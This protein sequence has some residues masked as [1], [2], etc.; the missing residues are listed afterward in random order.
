MPITQE[1]PNKPL[2]S[3]IIP[4]YNQASF[5]N[6]TF[7]SISDQTYIHWEAIIIDDGSTDNTGAIAIDWCNKDGRFKYFYKAN[8]GLSDARN[9]GISKALGQYIQFLDSDDLISPNKLLLQVASLEKNCADVSICTSEFF[10]DDNYHNR[11]INNYQ[12][13]QFPIQNASG[14]DLLPLFL[15][16]NRFPVSSPLLRRQTIFEAGHFDT[17]LKSLEDWDYWF[18][19]L[20]LDKKF[21]LDFTDEPLT[22]IRI[23]NNSMSTNRTT[24]TVS[25][26][27]VYKKLLGENHPLLTEQRK[28]IQF[29]IHDNIKQYLFDIE[30]T[31]DYNVLFNR[32]ESAISL[33]L[34]YKLYKYIF[35]LQ[36]VSPRK[37]L[38]LIFDMSPKNIL[39]I[40]KK[41]RFKNVK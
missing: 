5:L 41:K 21:S 25:R 15:T 23:R 24:M 13:D 33:P 4:C 17:Q 6:E 39:G 40:I 26:I 11:F 12:L 9:F 28:N 18:R 38:W 35:S 19:I 8:G 1:S 32:L 10:Y 3:I 34:R 22:S 7:I 14:C 37:L 27:V 31:M 2:V 29:Y 36:I 16:D 20:L 30:Y